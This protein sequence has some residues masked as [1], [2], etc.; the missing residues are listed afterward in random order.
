MVQYSL[1]GS[2]VVFLSAFVT[3]TFD[4]CRYTTNRV[5]STATGTYHM[6]KSVLRKGVGYDTVNKPCDIQI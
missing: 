5:W 4:T 3:F 2:I 1:S 6:T